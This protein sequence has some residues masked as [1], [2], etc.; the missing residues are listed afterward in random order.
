MALP[1][2]RKALAGFYDITAEGARLYV[3]ASPGAK[4]DEITGLWC[5]A[6][7]ERRL[8]VR[9]SAPPDKGRANAA[10]LKL[11]AKALHMPKSAFCLAIGETSRLKTVEIRGGETALIEALEKLAVDST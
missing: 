6:G 10:V 3:R 11:L 8:A 2:R 5:G 4:T 7:G 9:V 1:D